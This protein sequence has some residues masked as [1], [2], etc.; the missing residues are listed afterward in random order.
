M[1]GEQTF[2]VLIPIVVVKHSTVGLC[3]GGGNGHGSE[4]STNQTAAENEPSNESENYVPGDSGNRIAM[5]PESK[6]VRDETKTSFNGQRVK[7]DSES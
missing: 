1:G 4:L 2:H 5:F 6:E 3:W 7:G